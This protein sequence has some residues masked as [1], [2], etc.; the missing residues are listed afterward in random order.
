MKHTITTDQAKEI[1][2]LYF[3]KKMTQGRI[4]KIYGRSRQNINTIIKSYKDV[5]NWGQK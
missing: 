3:E 1:L 4:A 5:I 2:Y